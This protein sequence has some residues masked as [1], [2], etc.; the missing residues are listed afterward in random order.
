MDEPTAALSERECEQLYK[1]AE[2]LRDNG[3]SIIFISHRI[4]DMYRLA[5]RVTVFRDA[6]YI[7]TF[8]VEG[9]PKEKL[10]NAM[11]AARS[12]TSTPSA[13]FPSGTWC[14]AP[15]ACAA[16]ACSRTSAS[17]SAP[18]R[19]WASPAGRRRPYGGL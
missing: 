13:R 9:L 5:T 10:I 4:E 17:T 2:R 18:A 16:R 11:S 7:D 6:H 3:T 14:S 1:I 12:E 8:D 15:R 19:S